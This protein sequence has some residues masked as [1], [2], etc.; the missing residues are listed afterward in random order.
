MN[1]SS[2]WIKPCELFLKAKKAYA[3]QQKSAALNFLAQSLRAD[4]EYTLAVE[5]DQQLKKLSEKDK[6]KAGK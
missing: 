3:Q 2:N 4:P 6:A 1:K 5:F